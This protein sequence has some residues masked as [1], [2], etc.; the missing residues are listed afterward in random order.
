MTCIVILTSNAVNFVPYFVWAGAEIAVAMVC[1]GVPTLRPLYLK[2]RGMSIGYA[3]RDHSRAEEQ[4]PQFTMV[5]HKP[6][7]VFDLES[8]RD[9]SSASSHTK[10]E[11][12]GSGDASIP[13]AP[14]S[15]HVRE[16]AGYD[17]VDEIYSLYDEN[18]CQHPNQNSGVIWV[19]SEVQVSRNEANWPL[20]G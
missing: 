11:A 8:C 18:G 19:K 15:V 4:L 7:I 17:S 14:P 13:T 12:S 9:S 6:P 16:P 2:K 20:K 10:V 3:D 5:D 1:L